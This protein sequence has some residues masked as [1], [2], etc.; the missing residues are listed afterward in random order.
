MFSEEGLLTVIVCNSGYEEEEE[1][2]EDEDTHRGE[3]SPIVRLSTVEKY[4]DWKG[5][6]DIWPLAFHDESILNEPIYHLGEVFVFNPAVITS[7][8]IP[9]T[10]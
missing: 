10:Y 9:G 2:E 4:W 3:F 8:I 5:H 7:Y 6:E 1:E